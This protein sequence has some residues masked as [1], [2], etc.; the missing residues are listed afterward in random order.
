MK[1]LDYIIVAGL[2]LAALVLYGVSCADFAFPGESARLLCI[3]Q[4]LE[5]VTCTPYPLMSAFARML[6]G[7]NAIAPLCGVLSVAMMY[8]LSVRFLRGQMNGENVS[9]RPWCSCSLRPFA[10][11]PRTPSP[12]SSRRAG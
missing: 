9:P 2:A 6:G 7:G 12:G 4:G 1:K 3:W 10:T 11:P 5:T 8:L